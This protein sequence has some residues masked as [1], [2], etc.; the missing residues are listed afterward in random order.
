MRE[1]HPTVEPRTAAETADH[2][3]G[4]CLHHRCASLRAGMPEVE[5]RGTR[6]L[7]PLRLI[8][9]IAKWDICAAVK[10]CVDGD[11]RAD[12]CA[13]GV[14]YAEDLDQGGTALL[15]EAD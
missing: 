13:H 14:R 15:R 12:D 7:Q 1:A 5:Q 2:R 9:Q 8:H 11:P 4:N 10:L 3:N 6:R